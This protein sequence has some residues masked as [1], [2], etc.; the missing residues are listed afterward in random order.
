L[1]LLSNISGP[2]PL[3]GTRAGD[4]SRVCQ[5]EWRSSRAECCRA[6]DAAAKTQS[7]IIAMPLRYQLLTCSIH[8]IAMLDIPEVNLPYAHLLPC[9]PGAVWLRPTVAASILPE[10]PSPLASPRKPLNRRSNCGTHLFPLPGHRAMISSRPRTPLFPVAIG[11]SPHLAVR[12]ALTS[13]E[14]LR[15]LRRVAAS[16][17][18]P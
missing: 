7:Y 11:Y 10:H 6:C 1:P 17:N 15:F 14:S 12:H 5:V 4:W 3:Q 16:Q 18:N 2:D 8:A 13:L 9:I